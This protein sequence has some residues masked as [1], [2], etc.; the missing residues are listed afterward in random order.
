MA[1]IIVVD[2]VSDAGM[3]VKRI[4][5]RKGHS[6]TAFTEEEEALKH[7]AEKQVDLAIL[8]IKLKKMTGV[9]VLEELKKLNPETK[10][11]MLTGYP[12]L[13]TARE[14]LRLGAQEYC[15]KPI[16]KDELE[17]KVAEVMGE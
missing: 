2:D 7:A 11:I 6:V 9:D 4:L 3:L 14:S 13:E 16:N 10:A 15:V 12:T 1:N 17:T 8:D 5:E